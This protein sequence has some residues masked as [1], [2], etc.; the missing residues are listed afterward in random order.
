MAKKHSGP[1]KP[2]VADR[3]GP[4]PTRKPKQK[5]RQAP[6]K[7]PA[8]GWF[9]RLRALLWPVFLLPFRM[10]WALTWRLGL[11]VCLLISLGVAYFASTLP[12][13]SE[14]IDGRAAGSVTLMDHKGT[15]FAW[16]GDQFGGMITAQ[17]I[18]P[19]LKAAVVATEDRRFYRHF[20]I[21]PRGMASAIR[22]NLSE[23]RGPL[24][25]HGGSTITQQTAKLVCLGNSFDTEKWPS[26]RAYERQCRQ[27]TLWRKIKEASFALAMELRYSKD[28]ILT[29]YLNRVSL[30]A[31]ARGFEAAAQRYFGKSA[32]QVNASEAAMLAGLLKAPSRLAPTHN[33]KGAQARAELVLG[34]MLRENYLSSAEA[35]FASANP[36]T[37]SPAA[38]A[39]AGGYFAD[40]IMTTGPRYFTRNTTEDVLIQTTLDQSIQT[41]TEQAVRRVFED[42]VSKTSTAEVAVVVMNK[43]GA[44]RAMIGGRD[45]RATGAFNRATQARR[46]TGSAFKPFVYAAAL[47]LGHTPFDR[48]RDEPITINIPGSGAWSP[49]NYSKT[50]AG[51]VSYTQALA[52]SLN[53]PAVK[54]SEHIGR[55]TVQKIAWDFGLQDALADGPAL[56]LGTS[57]ST[58]IAMTG[59]YAGIL[60]GGTSV[61]PYGI[62]SLRLLGE[63]EPLAGRTGG[64]GERVI[65]SQTAQEL[66]YMMHEVIQSGTGQRAQI[67][68]IEIAGKTGTTQAARDAWFIGFTSDFVI[69]VWMGYDDNRPL[70]GVTGGSIPADIWR[71]TMLAITE[72]A[73]PGP[74]P[75]LRDRIPD[76][77]GRSPIDGAQE[78][79]ETKSL[80]QILFGL[81][82]RQN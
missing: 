33:L 76:A 51:E 1:G 81:F 37:L 41:A 72:Q 46:Q 54:I 80:T 82:S 36:A 23:G 63:R 28:E 62:T 7:P 24:S 20:G 9:G 27:S 65:R 34:L 6:Q 74:L 30:G 15:V 43:E 61:Q 40:W 35:R 52:E 77:A 17:T 5:Q 2:L 49:S 12:E 11:V 66:T 58:L 42:K 70:R 13:A 53:I 64:I 44:V 68:G 55:D 22:I 56:A 26:E 25:G 21:S 45:T 32:N 16:R 31:G 75:M 29:I 79:P 73:K 8:K 47:E 3:R 78:K 19:F 14:M 39:R 67:D 60:N 50:F 59:A 71:E 69:G 38:T 57:E 4:Q 48:V 10:L 18:S